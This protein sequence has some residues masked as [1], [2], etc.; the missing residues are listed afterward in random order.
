LEATKIVLSGCAFLV[1]FLVQL[2]ISVVGLN[3]Y[4]RRHQFWGSRGRRFKSGLPNGENPCACRLD[5]RDTERW[6]AY[7][8]AGRGE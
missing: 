3:S 1:A 4:R 2:G 5:A 7:S 6:S 8:A